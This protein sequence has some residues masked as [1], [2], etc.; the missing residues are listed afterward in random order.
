M[1]KFAYFNLQ[2]GRVL[3]WINTESHNCN[4]PD[5]SLLHPCTAAEWASR[6]QGEM[7]VQDGIVQP[8]VKLAASPEQLRSIQHAA[9]RNGCDQALST[10]RLAYPERE[11]DSWPQQEI[12]ARNLA[13][14][15]M[16]P[17]PLLA[18]IAQAR[19]LTITELAGRVRAKA[20]AYA[21]AAG[22]VIGLKQALIDKLDAVDIRSPD[23]LFLISAI[24][25]EIP[26]Q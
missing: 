11:V 1:S 18:A 26:P 22:K 17:T 6:T 14:N 13:A 8:Y 25:W 2:D 10:L 3:Q 4:L 12:E 15:P 20:D 24:S 9:I 19:G 7:M 16:A 5:A 23:A 21:T